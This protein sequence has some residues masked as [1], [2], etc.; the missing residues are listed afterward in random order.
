MS[1]SKRSHGVQSPINAV[2]STHGVEPSTHNV[3]ACRPPRSS[4]R[5]SES[6]LST[7]GKRAAFGDAPGC[8]WLDSV[9]R[10]STRDRNR[11]SGVGGQMRLVP[12]RSV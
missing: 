10:T 11:I 5:P 12:G 4:S 8:D 1:E 2:P 3:A 6:L 9:F 7:W